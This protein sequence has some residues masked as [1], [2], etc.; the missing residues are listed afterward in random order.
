MNVRTTMKWLLVAMLLLMVAGCQTTGGNKQLAEAVMAFEQGRYQQAVPEIHRLAE[1]GNVDA[2]AFLGSMYASGEGIRRNLK[3]AFYWQEK[4]AESGHARAQ[5]NLGVMYSRGMGT[6][7]NMGSAA[8]WFLQAADQGLAEAYLHL[9]LFHEKGWVLRK[10]PY[11]ASQRYY[12]AGH[13]FLERGD[14][15][16]ARKA[17]AEI[18]RL[19]PNHSLVELL[20]TEIFLQE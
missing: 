3:Q 10:C 9:G 14:L 16:N 18:R 6:K 17:L 15:R 19:L 12:Q 5:Y 13:A 11:L 2:Q 1:S 20:S 4:A 7:Q 8:R